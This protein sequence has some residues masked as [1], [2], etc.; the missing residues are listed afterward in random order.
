[1]W[2]GEEQNSDNARGGSHGSGSRYS[3]L[4]PLH[5]SRHH[6]DEITMTAIPAIGKG[7][8]LSL[9]NPRTV[10]HDIEKTEPRVLHGYTMTKEVS[11]RAVCE[12]IRQYAFV[13]SD[14][15]VI[16]SLEIHAGAEQ[17]QIMVDIMTEIWK[18]LLV[19]KSNQGSLKLPMLADLTRKI[20][21][22][23]KGAADE[24]AEACL[25]QLDGLEPVKAQSKSKYQPTK[26]KGHENGKKNEVIEALSD[27]GVHMRS[28]HFKNL[29]SPE[30]VI[31]NHVF[32]LS[33]KQLMELH[34]DNG[35]SLFSHNRDFMMRAFPS[36]TR[37]SS[38]NLDPGYFWRKGVQMVA[39]NWQTLDAGMMQNEGMFASGIGWVL[40]PKGYRE[41]SKN[42][43]DAS[44][45]FQT[46]ALAGVKMD[47]SIE[48]LAAQLPSTEKAECYV[49][50][51]CHVEMP[52]ESSRVPTN[53]DNTRYDTPRRYK[54]QTQTRKGAEI[55]FGGELVRFRGISGFNEEL[56]FLR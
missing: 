3:K 20:L 17:Q 35:L 42:N 33:E 25:P 15:P 27:L 43:H 23:V 46:L 9:P 21:I 16:V 28:Y 53:S 2:D 31:P 56:N 12:T 38:S 29:S 49:K 22:K 11:F 1:M 47:L 36:G 45:E 55:D 24:T 48:V 50:I 40:K 13:S 5:L 18:G 4:F 10:T 39:L 26:T 44:T 32:S 8:S 14:L 6:R 7:H 34:Q 41:P 52:D 54:Q 30:A 51:E 37:V 19:A